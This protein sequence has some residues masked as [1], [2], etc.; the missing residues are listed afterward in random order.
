MLPRLLYPYGDAPV[1]ACYKSFPEDFE[2]EEMLGFEPTG[3]GEHLFIWV[4]KTGLSTPELIT[5]IANDHAVNAAHISHSGL[6]DKHAVTRQWLSLHLPGQDSPIADSQGDGYRVL[7]QVRHLKKLRPGSHK[8]NRFRL[9][10]RQ[11]RDFGESTRQQ[12]EAVRNAG[13]ANYFGEQRFGRQQDNVMRALQELDKRR[14]SRTRRGLLVSALR[15]H[16]FN[17]ILRRRI[18]L[19]CWVTPLPGDVFMLRGSHSIFSDDLDAD[20]LERYRQLDISSCASLYGSG[21]TM[22][23]AEPLAIEQEIFAQHPEIVACLERQRS[24]LQMRPLRALTEDLDYSYDPRAGILELELSLPA[25]SYVTSLLAH[26]LQARD[27][28]H[29]R[30]QD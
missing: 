29:D 19:D 27:A 15:S 24:Q 12:I 14:L 13:F 9:R 28:S 26:F 21:A 5:R 30:P 17:Q 7:R 25:G 8:A 1:A 20:F 10:L 23:T 4:E 6:K 22:L 16:L 11:V 3:E 2:V 18:E